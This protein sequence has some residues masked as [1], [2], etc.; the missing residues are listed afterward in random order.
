MLGSD[1]HLGINTFCRLIEHSLPPGKVLCLE[2]IFMKGEIQFLLKRY[3]TSEMILFK[4]KYNSS[5]NQAY[6]CGFEVVFLHTNLFFAIFKH[7]VSEYTILESWVCCVFLHSKL[8]LIFLRIQPLS[9][10]YHT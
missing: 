10:Q 3:L 8:F 6:H 5:E 1:I 9:I 2:V 7:T 4:A